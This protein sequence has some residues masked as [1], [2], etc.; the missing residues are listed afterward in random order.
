MSEHSRFMQTVSFCESC[1]R[2]H[3]AVCA[4]DASMRAQL[5]RE[6]DEVREQLERLEGLCEA[7]V[8]YVEA[9]SRDYA[10]RLAWALAN[11]HDSRASAEA[12]AAGECPEREHA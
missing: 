6:R 11:H 5:Q 1:D 3:R 9:S 4:H 2:L 10:R 7:A 12:V 8:P